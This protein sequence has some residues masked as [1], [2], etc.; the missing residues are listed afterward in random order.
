MDAKYDPYLLQRHVKHHLHKQVQEENANR[1]DL[2]AVQDNFASFEAHVVKTIQTGLGQFSQIVG[3]QLESAR[4][5][6]GDMVGVAQRMPPDF[7]WNGFVKRNG[8]LLIDPSAGERNVRNI[9]FPNMEHRATQPLIAGALSKKGKLLKKYDTFYYAVTPSKYLHEFKSD[10]EFGAEPHPEMS[11]YLPDCLIG[12]LE[13]QKFSV[14]GKDVSKGKLGGA[15]SMSHEFVFKA[16]TPDAARKWWE[17]IRDVAGGSTGEVPET[18]APSSPVMEKGGFAGAG[19]TGE[20]LPEYS[21]SQHG[22]Q[23][24]GVQQGLQHGVAGEKEGVA[25]GDGYGSTGHG[26]GQHGV[27]QHGAG[28]YGAVQSGAGQYGSGVDRAPGQY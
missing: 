23:Q 16:E 2:L 25:V 7:E 18:S 14:K 17:V 24:G 22:Y 19:A 26:A 12:G 5:M 1:S 20:R 13:G 9:A 28:Q 10:D 27:G 11:L 6:Y 15:L 8:N 4:A 3:K 21:Q